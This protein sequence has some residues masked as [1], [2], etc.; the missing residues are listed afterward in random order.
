MKKLV[1][2]IVILLALALLGLSIDYNNVKQG[3]KPKFALKTNEYTYSIGNVYEYIGFG[4]KIIDYSGVSDYK[5]IDVGTIFSNVKKVEIDSTLSVDLRGKISGQMLSGNMLVETTQKG[6][7]AYDKAWVKIDK[8][9]I[10]KKLSTGK[11][12]SASN[13]TSDYVLEIGFSGKATNDNPPWATAN[14][15]VILDQ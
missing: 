15:I 11:I 3:L 6:S 12:T 4:Y 2:F 13:I 14:Y 10:I 8:N 5:N 1:I 9:T 7:T